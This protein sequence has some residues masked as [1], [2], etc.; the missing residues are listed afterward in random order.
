MSYY[1]IKVLNQ[2]FTANSTMVVPAGY[3]ITSISMVNTTANAVTG[4]IRIGTTD[5]GTDIAVAI[6]IGANAILGIPDATILKTLFATGSDTTI[7]LQ[8]VVAWNSASVNVSIIIS[9]IA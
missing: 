1:P 3:M 4:G 8:A 6:A 5:G 2:T 7:Y 9:K